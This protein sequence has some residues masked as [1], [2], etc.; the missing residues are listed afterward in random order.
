MAEE[1]Q[2]EKPANAAKA[3]E[4]PKAA[5]A[6]AA[7]G[8]AVQNIIGVLKTNP[9]ARYALIGA[10]AIA[11]LAMF[12]GGGS[13]VQQKQ[14]VSVTAG[15]PVTLENP[16]GGKSHLTTVPGMVSASNAEEDAEQ[17]VCIAEAGNRGT[18]EEE[19][20]VGLLSYVKVKVSEGNCQGKSGWTSKINIK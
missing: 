7:A 10:A 14:I 12:M 20:V 4:A 16:N 13:E 17:S 11:L 2:G 9:T 8:N 6:A 3:A 1:N 15:Q 5:E 18:V 19:Q